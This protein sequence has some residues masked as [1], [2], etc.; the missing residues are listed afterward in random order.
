MKKDKKE[1]VIQYIN[2]LEGYNGY[3]QFS[4]REIVKGKDIFHGRKIEVENEKGFIYE[5]NFCNNENS[6][7]IKQINNAW[8]ISETDISKITDEDIEVYESKYGA[9]IQMAQ[10]WKSESDELCENMNVKKLKKVVFAGFKG[11]IK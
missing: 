3:V 8:Y 10:I 11:D 4:H 9:K 1:E 6:I 7:S 5:A 2:S